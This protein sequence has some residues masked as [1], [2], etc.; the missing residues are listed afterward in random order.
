MTI[1]DVHGYNAALG[2][3]D[4]TYTL[5][6]C[7]DQ[8]RL[9]FVN[10]SSHSRFYIAFNDSR[11]FNIT[12]LD[13]IDYQ[14]FTAHFL[15]LSPGQRASILVGGYDEASQYC[16]SA[17]LL[18]FSDPKIS[19]GTARCPMQFPTDGSGQAYGG[20]QYTH[21][22]L[23]IT[24]K[25][26]LDKAQDL[27]PGPYTFPV[28]WLQIW[29]T[30][31]DLNDPNF[32]PIPGN[33]YKIMEV[34]PDSQ[35]QNTFKN[36]LHFIDYFTEWWNPANRTDYGTEPTASRTGAGIISPSL[37]NALEMEPQ[38]IIPM[39]FPDQAQVDDIANYMHYIELSSVDTGVNP[40][41][42]GFAAMM[43]NLGSTTG[44]GIL[45]R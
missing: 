44:D 3:D 24:G 16:S 27:F 13:G 40:A 15:D 23:E 31:A 43:E 17:Y 2:E 37:S 28:E 36:R 18:A 25:E 20:V 12:E 10:L 42:G 26:S 5:A 8:K 33:N 22:Y 38:E 35:F 41:L 4:K 11:T 7:S 34:L 39:W 21:A 6:S 9:R 32:Q 1:N 19:H 14:P 29:T 30:K 45:Q